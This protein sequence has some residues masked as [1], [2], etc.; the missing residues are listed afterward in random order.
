MTSATTPDGMLLGAQP[1]RAGRCRIS[2]APTRDPA[3]DDEAPVRHLSV[4]GPHEPPLPFPTAQS[5]D[6]RAPSSL[7]LAI[8]TDPFAPRAT[9]RRELPDPH[10]FGRQFVQGLLEVIGGRRPIAQLAAHT[11]VGVHAG[12]S[13]DLGRRR[14]SFG[15]AMPVLHSLHVMEPADGVAELTAVVQFGTRFRAIAGRLEGLDGRWRCVRM[16]IG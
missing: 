8:R 4:V 7:R 1:W 5:E 16:Q 2:V 11:S 6:L 12:L 10:R 9:G 14:R 15:P 13:R 3:F